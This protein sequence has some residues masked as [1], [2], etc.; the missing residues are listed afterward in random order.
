MAKVCKTEEM[1]YER[2][3]ARLFVG[4]GGLFWVAAVFGMDFGYRDKGVFESMQSALI[5]LAIVVVVLAIGWFFENLAAALLAA[6]AIG[7]VVWGV[8]TNW[9]S[10]VWFIMAA[11]LIAPM[12]ISGAL[13]FLA[14]RMQRICEFKE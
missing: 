13:F 8:I 14:G 2:L 7:A 1:N 11:V 6:G 4:A 5:P 10:G 3:F 9:E 12:V